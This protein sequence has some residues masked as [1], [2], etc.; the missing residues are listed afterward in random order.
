MRQTI[1]E[2]AIEEDELTA[3]QEL[4]E[5]SVDQTE[6]GVSVEHEKNVD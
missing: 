6:S 5:E 3:S 2:D 1:P 4:V